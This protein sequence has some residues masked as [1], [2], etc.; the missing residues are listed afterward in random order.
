MIKA[1][2]FDFDGLILDTETNEFKAYQDV[3][4]HHGAEL[5]LDVWSGVIGTDMLSVFDPYG[6]LEKLTGKPVD[7]DLFSR[8][9]RERFQKRMELEQLRPGVV[10][11]LEQAKRLGLSIGLASSSYREWVVGYLTQYGILD[12]FS[13]IRTRDYVEKVKPDPA[14]YVQAVECLGVKPDEAIAFED[15]ANGAL[16]AHR[17]GLHCVIVPNAVTEGLA[18][19]EHRKRLST[20]EGLHLQALIAELSS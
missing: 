10:S 6:H 11:T 1:V 15:S 9:R 13:C 4:R 17:A 16:A 8:M 14:L 7:R 20:M 19:G 2:V 18:F 5:T 12:F 3:Y